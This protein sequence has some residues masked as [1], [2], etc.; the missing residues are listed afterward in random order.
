MKEKKKFRFLIYDVEVCFR[1][2]IPEGFGESAAAGTYQGCIDGKFK[3]WFKDLPAPEEIAHECWHLFMQIMSFVDS[4][5]HTFEELISEIYAYNFHIFFCEVVKALT[6]M[7]RY[8]TL[9][10]ERSKK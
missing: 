8:K 5:E 9:Y 4:H 6:S 7:K 3:M 10:E 2:D 1:D